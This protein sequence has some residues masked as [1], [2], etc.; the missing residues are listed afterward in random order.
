MTLHAFGQVQVRHV[1]VILVH[2]NLKEPHAGMMTNANGQEQLVRQ[3]LVMLM[4]MKL[5][6]VLILLVLGVMTNVLSHVVQ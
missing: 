1:Q 3:T 5:N 6:V 2:T 4:Q